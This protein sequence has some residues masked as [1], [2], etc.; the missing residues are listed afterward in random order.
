VYLIIIFILLIKLFSQSLRISQL[1]TRL[2]NLAQRLALS[3]KDARDDETADG[4]T[5]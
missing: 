5:P 3:E 1:D 2:Q 4:K